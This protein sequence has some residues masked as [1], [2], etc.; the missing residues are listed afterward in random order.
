V[1]PCCIGINIAQ[2]SI[3]AGEGFEKELEGTDVYHIIDGVV[4]QE[5]AGQILNPNAPPTTTSLASMREQRI[6]K[7]PFISKCTK[8]YPYRIF[9]YP[10]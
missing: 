5:G 6:R 10:R 3:V 2:V 4:K 7:C 1:I 9:R 8:A